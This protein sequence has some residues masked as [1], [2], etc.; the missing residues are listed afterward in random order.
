MIS[1]VCL[2]G[3]LAGRPSDTRP[4]GESPQV[5][6]CLSADPFCRVVAHT[7]Q[8]LSHFVSYG[9]GIDPFRVPTT[10][11]NLRMLGEQP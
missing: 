8:A 7:P 3:F 2:R 10:E 11:A 1:V 9:M 6:S 4:G 5:S